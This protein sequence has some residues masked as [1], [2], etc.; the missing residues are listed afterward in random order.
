MIVSS[1]WRTII[2]EPDSIARH[3]N[4]HAKCRCKDTFSKKLLN[5]LET[6][7]LDVLEKFISYLRSFAISK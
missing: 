3:T 6:S 2:A 7:A 5:L 4:D 1:S